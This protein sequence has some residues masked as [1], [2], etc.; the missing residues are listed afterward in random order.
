MRPPMKTHL[1]R[2]PGLYYALGTTAAV[3]RTH[4]VNMKSRATLVYLLTLVACA[5]GLWFILRVGSELQAPPDL[6]G[7]WEISPNDSAA[8]AA[9]PNADL[10]RTMVVEQSG[11]YLQV[12]FADGLAADLRFAEDSAAE[13]QPIRLVGRDWRMTAVR[14]GTGDLAVRLDGPQTAEF[15][16]RRPSEAP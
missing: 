6:S 2:S 12:R 9:P 14:R 4:D 16:A 15:L 7:T 3:G 8:A 11:R 5:G 10:G 1:F 13:S